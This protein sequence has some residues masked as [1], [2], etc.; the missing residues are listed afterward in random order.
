MDKKVIGIISGKGGV[1]KTS[2]T[3]SLAS[4]AVKDRDIIPIVLD[5]DVDAPNL[6]LILPAADESKI[7]IKDTYTTLKATFIEDDCV[8]CK[9][10][11]DD[12]FCEFNAL[13]WS[14]ENSLPKIDYIKCEGCGACKVL[15]PE[16][17]FEIKWGYH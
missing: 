15:C 1:G 13:H 16:N 7:K 3:A 10:C 5:C 17:A 12:H 2:L 9:Q 8:Q 14:K 11:I 4:L 6:A